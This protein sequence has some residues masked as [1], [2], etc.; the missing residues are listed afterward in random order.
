[1]YVSDEVMSGE[2]AP[3]GGGGGGGGLRISIA[4]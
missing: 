2:R 3:S 1:M 4:N